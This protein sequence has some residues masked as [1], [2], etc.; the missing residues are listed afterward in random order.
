MVA[1]F[2]VSDKIEKAYREAIG[3]VVKSWIPVRLKDMS[4]THWLRELASVSTRKSVVNASTQV[5][6]KM[7]TRV[8][9]VNVK[10]WREAAVKAQ[11]SQVIY[12]LLR[13]ELT[14]RTAVRFNSIIE[15]Y[16][17]SLSEIPHDV[18]VQLFHEIALA[19]QQG[20]R[21]AALAEILKFR[22]PTIMASKINMLART[23]SSAA[24]TALTR[25]RSEE[26]DLPCFIWE[27]SQD[28][29]RVRPSHRNM[30]GVVVFWKD[31]PSPEVLI[32]QKDTLGPYA[33]GECPN[34]RC[35]A[36]PVLTLE[37]IYAR[38]NGI[39]RVFVN[40]RIERM[41]KLSFA[42]LSGIESR[43]AA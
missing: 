21:P 26:L 37:D 13:Q 19:Q 11:G 41:T 16:A 28:G 38:K 1:D 7:V 3:K 35:N 12:D 31:L 36:L 27:T 22:F 23:Q 9:V 29:R 33:P 42:K 20:T 15:E 8:D 30:Q 25:L 34:C 39:A 24:G 18:A 10:S 2:K 14:G 6:M 17:Q 4:P 5:A 43:L 32:G 40:G